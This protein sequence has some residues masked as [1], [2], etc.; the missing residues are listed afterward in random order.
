MASADKPQAILFVSH[1][2]QLQ[3]FA[4]I[5]AELRQRFQITT[6]LWTLGADDAQAGSATGGFNEVVN[7]IE[8]FDRF[9][10]RD[11]EGDSRNLLLLLQ[12]ERE[13]GRT[14]YHE[15]AALDR[16]L[17]GFTDAE[18]NFYRMKQRWTPSQIAAMAACLLDKAVDHLQ[19]FRVLVS[20]GEANTLPYRL[21]HRLLKTRGIDHLYPTELPH[22]GGRMYFEESLEGSWTRCRET[23]LRFLAERIPADAR[24][25]AESALGDIVHRHAKPEYFVRGRRGARGWSKRLAPARMV[26]AWREWRKA[27]TGEAQSNPRSIPPELLSPWGRWRRGLE[28]SRRRRYY[29]RVAT[30]TL[31]EQRFACYFL[32]V[33]PEYTVEGLA[34][35]YQDQVAL[36]RNLVAALPADMVL[37]VKEHKP[38]A[39]RR[40]VHFYGELASIPNVVLLHDSLD[41]VDVAKQARLVLTLT[42]TIALEAMCLGVPCVM[43]GNFYYE[44]FHGIYKARSITHFREMMACPEK[45]VAASREEAIAALAARYAVAH[46]AAYPGVEG[47]RNNAARLADALEQEMRWRGIALSPQKSCERA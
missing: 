31:P 17:I 5:A 4:L 33:Q 12:Y 8:G 1:H 38:E 40:S 11:A 21:V 39:G 26:D 20:V 27:G 45:L 9:A 14:C 16:S 10:R 32:H 42:G 35:E 36:A 37:L 41:S 7:L 34:F 23:Y 47:D 46:P 19:R 24:A 2:G 6:L 18:V 43:F 44:Q 3:R 15:D 28:V 13:C 25:F 29:E 22:A 30:R